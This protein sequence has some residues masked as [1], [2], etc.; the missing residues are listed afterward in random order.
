[1]LDIVIG[2]SLV[3]FLI[4]FLVAISLSGVITRRW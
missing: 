2:S 3:A 4:G 1:M